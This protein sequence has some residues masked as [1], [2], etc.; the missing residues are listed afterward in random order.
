MTG[1]EPELQALMN[2]TIEWEAYGET[3][4]W[5]GVTYSSPVTVEPPTGVRIDNL[6][7]TRGGGTREGSEKVNTNPHIECSIIAPYRSDP[8]YGEKDRITLPSGDVVYI[9]QVDT[10]YDETTTP[11]HVVI[12]ASSNQQVSGEAA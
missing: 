11:H 10:E 7:R 5:G 6:I 2:H 3:G 4:E 8:E 1:I 9:T 12:S